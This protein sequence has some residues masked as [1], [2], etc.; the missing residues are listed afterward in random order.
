MDYAAQISLR[1]AAQR[2]KLDNFSY[3]KRRSIRDAYSAAANCLSRRTKINA[4]GCHGEVASRFRFLDKS[5]Q[6]KPVKA[7]EKADRRMDGRRGVEERGRGE[8]RKEK[9]DLFR[10][11]TRVRLH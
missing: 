5:K 3:K 1:F 11:R 4:S 6:R 10:A 7:S 9:G 2:F 8:V